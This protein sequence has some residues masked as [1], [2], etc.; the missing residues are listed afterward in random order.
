LALIKHNHVLVDHWL[1]SGV[2]G[3]QQQ[4]AKKNISSDK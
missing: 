1:G 4:D 2:T 3:L